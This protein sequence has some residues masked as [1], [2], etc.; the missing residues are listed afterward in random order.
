MHTHIGEN[1]KIDKFQDVIIIYLLVVSIMYNFYHC[2]AIS[3]SKI[4]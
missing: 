4:L 2:L 1:G 3:Y